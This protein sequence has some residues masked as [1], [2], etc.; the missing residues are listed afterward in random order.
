VPGSHKSSFQ[1]PDNLPVKHDPPTS[2]TIPLQAGDVIAFSTNL[3]HD[4]SPWIEDYPRMNIFQRYQLS[5]YFN[6]T[7]K[8]GY[9]LEEYRDQISD[10]QYELESLSKEEK[11]SVRRALVG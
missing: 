1:T 9:P 4:A 6:E 3:L 5:V 11:V 8:G 7:G 2:V 10:E